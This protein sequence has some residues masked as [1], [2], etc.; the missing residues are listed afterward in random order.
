[1]AWAP[2]DL[3]H[4]EG[5]IVTQIDDYGVAE[6]EAGLEKFKELDLDVDALTPEENVAIFLA[7]A[8]YFGQQRGL[9][10][11]KGTILTHITSSKTWTTPPEMRYGIHT[12]TRLAWHCDMGADV[13]ALYILS[14][15]ETGGD[16]FVASSWTIYKELMESYPGVLRTLSDA[17]WPIQISGNPPRYISAPLLRLADGKIFISVDPGRLGLHPA[18]AETGPEPPLPALSPSQLEALQIL[19]NLACK[20]QHRLD[21][22]PG[23]IVFINNLALLHARDSYIDPAE[24]PGR[25]LV[26]LWLR[27]P[28]LAWSIPQAMRVPWEAAFGP[29]GR[30]FPDRET[31][32]PAHP[33]LEYK[34]P[35]YT[36]GSAAFIL[37]DDDD[38][39]GEGL[40]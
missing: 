25:H 6:V 39:N 26:R 27:N 7:I 18:T 2:N 20:N 36:A 23:D 9:Q 19:S 11:K 14:L 32:Y 5:Q 21:T 16:T 10:D 35:K 8:N 34:P 31:R 22:R 38:T 4:A 30:G 24:G 28:K 29:D 13:L 3:E 15:A 33:T 12:T 37:G 1:M 17:S 40:L